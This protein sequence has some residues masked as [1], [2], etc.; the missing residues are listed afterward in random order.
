MTIN[1]YRFDTGTAAGGAGT[2]TATSS[3]K[4]IKGNIVAVDVE[5]KDSPPA[6]TTDITVRTKGL[7]GQTG[8]NILVITDGAT[9]GRRYVTVPLVDAADSGVTDPAVR[10]GFPVDDAVDVVIAQA[11]VGDSAIVTLLVEE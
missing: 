8:T 2:A 6:A 7:S 3:E 10:S 9:D 11:N 4:P 5:Y 1:A